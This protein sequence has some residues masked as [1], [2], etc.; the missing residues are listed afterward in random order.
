MYLFITIIF[1]NNIWSNQS[2]YCDRPKTY[3]ETQPA[4]EARSWA[5]N[6]VVATVPDYVVAIEGRSSNMLKSPTG[7][8]TSDSSWVGHLGVWGRPFK[9]AQQHIFVAVTKITMW[10]LGKYCTIRYFC[11]SPPPG[12]WPFYSAPRDTGDNFFGFL[13]RENRRTDTHTVSSNYI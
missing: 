8:R 7:S 5:Q 9:W 12:L 2:S 11:Q 6:S 4:W 13:C 1:C 3:K 10:F